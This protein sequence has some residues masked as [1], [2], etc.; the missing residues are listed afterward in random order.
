MSTE[1]TQVAATDTP[2]AVQANEAVAAETAA[3][4]SVQEKTQTQDAVPKPAEPVIPE[5]YELKLDEGSLIDSSY[6]EK[7]QTYAKEK[8]LTQEQAQELIQ[9]EDATRREYLEAQRSKWAETTENWKK[10]A[11]ADAEI[12]G[13]KFAENVE[14]AHRALEKFSTPQFKQALDSSG[15]GNHPE[16][17]RVFARIGRMMAESKMIVPGANT[18]GSKE[19]TEIFYGNKN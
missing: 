19:L 14:H 13:E 5:K 3:A 4:A 18:G 15:Y 10:Q 2:N 12:G 6:L 16:L 8:K 17:V 7:F 11:Q 1:Q 9:R